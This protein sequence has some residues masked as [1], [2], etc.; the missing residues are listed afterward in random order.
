MEKEKNIEFIEMP[1]SLREKYQYFTE[2]KMD[3][4]RA[5]GYQ[6]EFYS[7]EDGVKDYVQ[8][9]LGKNNRTY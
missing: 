9:Y 3:Q 1:E 2:A 5:V 7:L 8:N 4:L 6:E